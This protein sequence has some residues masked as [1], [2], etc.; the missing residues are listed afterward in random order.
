V[1]AYDVDWQGD[2]IC[3]GETGWLV[4]HRDWQGMATATAQVLADPS[5][6]ASLASALRRRAL[7]MFDLR[8][9]QSRERDAYL[10]IL[11]R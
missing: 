6:A 8:K 7:S 9:G 3:D 4:P 2:I 11:E 10:F 5:G 1:V